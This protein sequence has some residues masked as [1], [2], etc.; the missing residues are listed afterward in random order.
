MTKN[1]QNRVK[2]YPLGLHIPYSS[3]KGV[4]RCT[5][6]MHKLPFEHVKLDNITKRAEKFETFMG[7]YKIRKICKWCPWGLFGLYGDVPLDRVWFFWPR[8]PKQSIQF[9]L[10]L[11]YTGS[12]PVL[13]R[14]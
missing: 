14:V 2:P 12:E 11:P 8:C 1:G 4:L 6:S 9:D 13:N 10:P 3:Y 7:N 5:F